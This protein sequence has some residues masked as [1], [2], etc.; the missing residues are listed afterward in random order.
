MKLEINSKNLSNLAHSDSREIP[1]N[2]WHPG[3]PR[4]LSRRI[5]FSSTFSNSPAPPVFRSISYDETTVL[6]PRIGIRQKVGKRQVIK[7]RAIFTIF[8]S[9][10]DANGVG[11]RKRVPS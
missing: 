10:R 6:Q 2:S 9:G 5:L 3:F 1:T 11:Q 4:I 7:Q 8:P